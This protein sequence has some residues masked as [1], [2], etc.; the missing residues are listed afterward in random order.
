ML[1]IFAASWQQIQEKKPQYLTVQRGYE[2][3]R[4]CVDL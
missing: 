3:G 4:R 2:S 1:P